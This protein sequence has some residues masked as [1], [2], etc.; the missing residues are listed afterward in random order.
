MSNL[1]TSILTSSVYEVAKLTAVDRAEKLSSSMGTNIFLKREDQQPIFSFKIRGAYNKISRL[2]DE[3]RKAGVIAVSAG[4]H[5]QG[6]AYSAKKLDISAVIIM[7]STTPSIKVEAV[8]SYGAEVIL[9][10]DNLA[11]AAAECTRLT[12]ELGRIFIHPYDDPLVIAG[13]GTVGKEI[14]EQLPEVT[15]VFVPVGGGGLIAGVSGY[16]KQI[17]PHVIVVGVEPDDAATLHTSFAK[18]ERVVLDH[19][20][21]FADGVAVRQVGKLSYGIAKHYVDYTITVSNDQLCAAIKQIFE[22]TRTIVE[23]AGALAVAGINQFCSES[24]FLKDDC[25]V[26]INSGANM[27]FERLQYVTE[28]TLIGSGQ[29]ALLSVKLPEKPGALETFCKGLGK[30][31]IS[32]F[33]YRQT[34]TSEAHILVGV[35]TKNHEEAKKVVSQLQNDGYNVSDLT[36]NDLAKEHIRHMIGGKQGPSCEALVHFNFP[37]RPGALADFLKTLSQ[38]WNISLFHYRGMG[39]DNGRVLIG[40]D[41]DSKHPAFLKFLKDTNFD[42]KIETTDPAYSTFLR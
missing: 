16:I 22:D 41:A 42:Y 10:G 2:S 8:E 17:A 15:H 7:P 39:A 33:N 35:N 30:H 13:Q 37:E 12:K 11:E 38:K 26:A 1:L 14:I 4:N 3:E 34:N 29:E 28:R 20:G 9:F 40:F 31:N 23:P 27:T 21:T 18:K 32:E 25:V 5:A 24:P 36:D 6:V 19:V